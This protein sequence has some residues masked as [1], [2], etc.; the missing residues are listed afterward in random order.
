[1]RKLAQCTIFFFFLQFLLLIESNDFFTIE[2]ISNEMVKKK[3]NQKAKRSQTI[4][5]TIRR[6]RFFFPTP[7]GQNKYIIN[8]KYTTKN[9]L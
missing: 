4:K 3:T 2:K 9:I 1:M 5:H 6:N 7:S 8:P